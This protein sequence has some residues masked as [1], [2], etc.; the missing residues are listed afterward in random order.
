MG[1]W[2]IALQSFKGEPLPVCV[3]KM[4]SSNDDLNF[5]FLYQSYYFARDDRV[6]KNFID[7]I[8]RHR[9][10]I[11]HSCT[12]QLQWQLQVLKNGLEGRSLTFRVSILPRTAL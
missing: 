9:A 10:E 1:A 3:L 11:K 5:L 12:R 2:A 8:D 6:Y 4:Y 7:R